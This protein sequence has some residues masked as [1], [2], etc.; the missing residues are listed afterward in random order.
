MSTS[1]LN[2]QNIKVYLAAVTFSLIV[3][4]S[5]LGVKTCIASAT[6]LEIL[7]HRFNFALLAGVLILA[8]RKAE[9]H[10][11]DKNKRNLIC[12][13]GLYIGFM[14][15]QTIG[16]I[17]ATSIA[18]GIIFAI[19]PILAK[20]I[21]GVFLKETTTWKQNIF[22]CLSVVAVI[23]MFICGSTDLNVKFIGWV[24]L[25]ASS[26]CMASSNV[27]MRGVR[28]T[29]T[30]FEIAI[31][32][33]FLGF[34]VFNVAYIIYGIKMNIPFSA[35]SMP[36]KNPK[37]FLAIVYLG[38]PSTFISSLLMSYMLANM[39][40]IKATVFGNLS[41]AISIVAGVVVLKEPLELYHILCTALIVVGVIGVSL[42][43]M[44]KKREEIAQ[45]VEKKEKK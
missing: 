15:L 20:L 29:Y 12:T 44:G 28:A 40:A 6:T 9:I 23:A 4:F 16:L 22:V 31:A 38:I 36:L 13:A 27:V 11:K 2:K 35:Y 8:S 19:I 3:G 25:F 10:I 30:P 33:A 24:I 21:A 45:I 1:S 14:L 41:T 39:E 26:L 42:P 5:F 34:I 32:I 43:T 17:F 37:F 7:V 18:A